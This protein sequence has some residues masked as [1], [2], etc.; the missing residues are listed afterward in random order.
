MRLN[1]GTPEEPLA[2]EV[3]PVEILL[4]AVEDDEVDDDEERPVYGLTRNTIR[5]GA[6]DVVEKDAVAPTP[7]S[8]LRRANPYGDCSPPVRANGSLSG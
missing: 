2:P 7:K 6:G 4:L 5:G 3:T 8:S 1:A